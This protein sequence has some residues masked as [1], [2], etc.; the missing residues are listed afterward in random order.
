M[1]RSVLICL[2]AL[3]FVHG[4]SITP[5]LD[6]SIPIQGDKRRPLIPTQWIYLLF[7]NKFRTPLQV[8]A[9]AM[10]GEW[11]GAILNGENVKKINFEMKPNDFREIGLVGDLMGYGTAACEINI[12]NQERSKLLYK[13]ILQSPVVG[14]NLLNVFQY[15]G[16]DVKLTRVPMHGPVGTVVATMYSSEFAKPGRPPVKRYTIKGKSP[17]LE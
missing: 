8:E 15:E 11:K 17:F 2:I 4:G 7:L 5:N 13:F 10:G 6:R 9:I 16:I 12:Y 1:L 14:T 3:S